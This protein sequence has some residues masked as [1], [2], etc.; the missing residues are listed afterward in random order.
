[1]KG[2]TPSR[3]CVA[4]ASTGASGLWQDSAKES[5]LSHLHVH[6]IKAIYEQS[7]ERIQHFQNTLARRLDLG[8]LQTQVQQ[9]S[10]LRQK[11]ALAEQGRGKTRTHAQHAHTT[12]SEMTIICLVKGRGWERRVCIYRR[13]QL[14][15][16]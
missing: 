2:S 3:P 5:V 8:G 15:E 4:G 6:R 1:M 14:Q 16:L 13:E 12:L 10:A 7:H 9:L 11:P